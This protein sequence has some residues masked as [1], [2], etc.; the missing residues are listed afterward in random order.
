VSALQ[1]FVFGKLPRHG[2]FV[3]RGL[4]AGERDAWDGWATGALALARGE[5]GGA[6]EAAHD[7]APP[8][9]FAFGAPPFG[10]RRL[11]GA[12]APSVDSAG[13]RFLIVVGATA[14]EGLAPDG[15][16]AEAAERAETAIY[17]AFGSGADV[18]GLAAAAQ[19]AVADLDPGHG[20]AGGRFWTAGP[21]ADGAQVIDAE[22]PPAGLVLLALRPFAVAP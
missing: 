19:A 15:A 21:A 3:S 1:A 12:F 6:F 10:P 13:R 17:D 8:W 14:P 4:S 20:S 11:A 22:R 5:L 7:A 16:G 2:D 18:D 9:R